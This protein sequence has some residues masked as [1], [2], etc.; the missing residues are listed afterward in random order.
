MENNLE[1][2]T[3]EENRKNIEMKNKINLRKVLDKMRIYIENNSKRK[4]IKRVINNYYEHRIKL[5]NAG[6]SVEEVE[7]Y[8]SFFNEY[9]E[10]IK[11]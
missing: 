10:L 2:K 5:V 4:K 11:I 6:F 3:V 7:R 1:K 9:K 8:D